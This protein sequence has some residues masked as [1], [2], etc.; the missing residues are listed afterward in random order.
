MAADHFSISPPTL[1]KMVKSITGQTFL[2]Y[3]EKQRLRMAYEM[4]SGGDHTIQETAAECGFANA[5]SFYK[6]FKRVY[7]Y[8]PSNI[9]S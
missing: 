5:N 9:R 3:V 2:V 4:L 8:P 7:G 6:A 1:Q